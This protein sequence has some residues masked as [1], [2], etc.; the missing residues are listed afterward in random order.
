MD[1]FNLTFGS[2]VFL[3]PGAGYGKEFNVK[4]IES[5]INGSIFNSNRYEVKE[6]TKVMIGQ[7]ANPPEELLKELK[8]LFSSI[9]EVK[10]AYNAHFYNPMMD[11]KPHTLIAVELNGDWESM[12]IEAGKI[13]DRVKIPDP[14]VD[15][16]Q[17]NGKSDLESYFKDTK[18]F[19][20]KKLLGI[21]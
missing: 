18:P 6:D 7:P 14:P 13:A 1:F 4:E 2:E 10:S 20:R 15:F 9:K 11:E 8:T 16:I 19:Y 17:L 3:N 5:I 12:I 21:F